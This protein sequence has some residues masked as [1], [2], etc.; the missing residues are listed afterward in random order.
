MKLIDM[1]GTK[2][3]RLTVIAR[4]VNLNGQGA[5]LCL[6][7]CGR[8]G[9]VRGHALRDGTIQGCGNHRPKPKPMYCVDCSKPI[10]RYAKRCRSCDSRIKPRSVT[11]GRAKRKATLPEYEVWVQMKGKCFRQTH[12]AY[13]NYGARGI[14]VCEEWRNNFQAFYDHVGPRASPKHTIE[15]INNNGNYEPGNV[16]WATRHEQN[17]NQR[18]NVYLTVDGVTKCVAD[19]EASSGTK[20]TTI[21]TRVKAGWDDRSAVYGRSQGPR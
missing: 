4:A 9:V 15:R 8:R 7:E 13:K 17:R 11:H 1:V 18:S 12:E 10:T 20:R 21:Y 5:W 6:C 3:G 19:W 16:K 2:W 14:T